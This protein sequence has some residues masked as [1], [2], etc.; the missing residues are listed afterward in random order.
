MA[1]LFN[2][3]ISAT[4]PGLIKT[5]DNAV[6]TATLRELT[7]GSGTASGVFMNTAGDFKV[8]AILEFGSLKDTGENIIITKFV[9]A[10]DGITNNNNDTSIPTSKAVKDFVETH[11]TAQ[12]LD[13]GG[14]G[15]TTGS[16]DLDSQVFQING[17]TN[18]IETSAS[19]QSITIGL[20]NSVTI[21]GTFTGAT[22]A[23]QLNGTISSSTTATTQSAGDNSTKIATTQYVDTLDAASDLDFSGDSGTGDVNLNTQVFAVTGTTNQIVTTAS[24]QGL[25]LSLPATVHRNL[26]G[27]VTG[28][29]TGDLTGN[30]TATSVLANGVT[31]TTQSSSDDSTKVATTSFVKS[32]NNASDLDFTTDSGTGAVVLNTETLSVLG[33]TNQIN[34]AG[35]GQAITL[36]LPSTVH[37]NLLGNVTGDLTGNADTATKWQ[38]ARDLSLTGQ[39]TGTISSV[40]GTSAVSGAVTLDNNSVTGKVLTGLAT[41]SSQSISA[42]DSILE[43]FGKV[44]SQVNGLANGLRF[45]GSWDADSNSPVLSDG[46]GE[47]AAGTTTGVASNKLIDSNASFTS[48]VLNDRVVN[49]VDGQIATVT[50]VDNGQQLTLSA[51]IMLSGEAYT[52]DNSPFITQGHYYVV[53]N[54]GATSLNGI[55]SWSI[56]DWVIAG[57]NNEWTKLDHSQVDGTGTPGN[58][59]KWSATQ[60]I[61][62]SIVSESGTAITVDGS[63]L[64]NTTL[65]STGNFAVNTNKFTANATSGNVAFTGDLAINTNK[66]TVNATTGNTVVAGTLD[67]TS[68]ASIGSHLTI[69]G[70]SAGTSTYQQWKNDGTL[71]AYNGSAAA[72]LS[73]GS[74]TDYVAGNTTG[75]TSVIL[76]TNNAARL[77]INSTTATFG[78][79]VTVGTNITTTAGFLQLGAVALPSA[80]V[81]AIT[82]RSGS[83]NLYIQTSSGNTVL[84]VD[85]AQNTMYSAGSTE[86]SFL[87]SNVPKLTINSSGNSTFAGDVEAS[88]IYVGATNTSFD[89]YN[90]GTSYFNGTVTVDAAFTQSGGDASTFSGNVTITQNSGSLQFSN[91]GSGHGSI[92]TGLSKDLNIGAASGNVYINNNTTFSGDVGIGGVLPSSNGGSGARVLGVHDGVGSGWAITK[93][94][95]TSTGTAAAD[96]TLFGIINLDAYIFNYETANIIFGT[97]SAERMRITSSGISEFKNDGT[98]ASKQKS[99]LRLSGGGAANGYTLIN[100]TYTATESQLNI[101]LGFSGS[102]VVISQN[103][104]VSA[105]VSNQYLSSN[106]QANT[107]PQAFLLDA[108]DFVFKN[109]QTSATRAVDSVVALDERMRIADDGKVSIGERNVFASGLTIEKSGNHLFLRASTATAGKYWNFDVASSNRLYIINNGNT[110]VYINDGDTSFT[111]SSDE[112][113]KENI[114][115]L[116]NVLDKI[117]D[118]RCVEYNLKSDDTKGKKIGFIAQDWQEDFAP[119]VDKDE[120]EMLG[121]KYTETIPVLLKAIQELKAE[122]DKLKQECKCKN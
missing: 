59:T 18:E 78:G 105:T 45:I 93:Y 49:Q 20:P 103:C 9:D 66:F 56:G 110:G 53:S 113:L 76:A 27:N 96:G 81:A 1:T 104:K 114:K 3:K 97:D 21:S 51:D 60:V 69:N 22:F 23:G 75:N 32:L 82:N 35:S 92:T 38:T 83:N 43:A 121:M 54:G 87:I 74:A 107:R 17:T 5:I 41:P 73:G 29:V 98:T 86:H 79:N 40:D 58:L 90:Q 117:K 50:A 33:T 118:Y 44:Q 70:V 80:G 111:G 42:T 12:D 89:F 100:D 109:T 55:S 11:V 112:I 16:V 7:D 63:L 84:L 122:V 4:Y 77:T 65:S 52:I 39:A 36:S 116:N 37:R 120:N 85:G 106:A 71:F 25:S 34:S 91:T 102:P 72:I 14:D 61:A 2:T 67:V 57:A 24:N 31:A 6:L 8:S 46:G 95:N 68:T 99:V 15:A 62:D 19:N 88:G 48:A 47:S 115:P 30:V 28:N 26:Q 101:G 13:F 10:A 119:I 108:G 94:T 64:T